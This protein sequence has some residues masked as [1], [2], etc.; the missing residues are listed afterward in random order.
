MMQFWRLCA[1]LFRRSKR[2]MTNQLMY[3]LI[4]HVYTYAKANLVQTKT[5][6]SGFMHYT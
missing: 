4:W 1:R 5:R 3:G 6:L 2:W